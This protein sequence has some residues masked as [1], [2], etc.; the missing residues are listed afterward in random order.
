MRTVVA[1]ALTLVSVAAPARQQRDGATAPTVGTAIVAGTVVTDETPPVPARRALLTLT[2]AAGGDSRTA[3][4]D[5]R[6]RFTF[7]G[8]TAGR[9]M[10]SASKGGYVKS[11][12]GATRPG[13]SGVP[14]AIGEGKRVDG[15]VVT[16]VRGGVITGTLRDRRGAPVRDGLV[17]ATRPGVRVELGRGIVGT[18]AV[19]ASA[20]TDDRGVYRIFGLRPGEYFVWAEG[21]FWIEESTT[22]LTTAED[23][24]RA[25]Q[26]IQAGRGGAPLPPSSA[27]ASMARPAPAV[28]F[29]D[30][31]YPGTASP[32]DALPVRVGPGEERDGIDLQLQIVP[33][34][35]LTGAVVDSAGR[36][37]KNVRVWM[38]PAT[39]TGYRQQLNLHSAADGTFDV[40]HVMP[41]EYLIGAEANLGVPDDQP[42]WTPDGSPRP[43][44]H[45]ARLNVS[46]NGVDQTGLALRLQPSLKVSGRVVFE[47]GALEPAD[48]GG[49]LV[50]LFEAGEDRL[51]TIPM[52]R[53][54]PDGTFVIEGVAA[55]RYR[56]DMTK[57]VGPGRRLP[58]GWTVKSITGAGP[59]VADVPLEVKPDTDVSGLV[60]TLTSRTT[61]LIGTLQD[62]A[63][64]PA[65]AYTVI[66]FSADRAYWTS[67][68]RRIQVGRPADDGG[69]T[70]KNLPAGEYLLAALTDFEEGQGFDPGFLSGLTN[71]AVKVTIVDGEKTVRNL[72]IAK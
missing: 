47:R 3:V 51:N 23:L 58:S 17:Y 57:P 70:F 8:L 63:G 66:A 69:F 48:P 6:G 60:I 50:P 19:G 55:A 71:S 49:L 33:T 5:D 62:A 11:M 34:A 72:T 36:P 13:G 39:S 43:Q 52:A 59:D 16:L 31:Y 15:L 24:Q 68:S 37:P 44:T 18:D 2:N 56:I 67:Q 4:A 14:L 20:T 45:W 54:S 28:R 25:R 53:T 40:P 65:T 26:L 41:G 21:P 10:L 9:F 32:A 38:R 30:S 42:V 27:A 22:R 64:R 12:Y 29:A 35:R 61:E 1:I 7:D 46:V